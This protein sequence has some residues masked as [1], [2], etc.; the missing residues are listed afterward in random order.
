MKPKVGDKM[1][2][3]Q[4]PHLS[5]SD[6]DDDGCQIEFTESTESE[7]TYVLLQRHFEPPDDG[8]VYVESH[9]LPICGHF[10][11]RRV[12]LRKNE[13]CFSLG[14]DAKETVQISFEAGEG[15]YRQLKKALSTM[16]PAR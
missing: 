12:E 3:F 6:C 10:R 4:L 16:I 2:R 11:I 5:I 1:L 13:L 15:Q 14:N 9:H 8:S 7:D